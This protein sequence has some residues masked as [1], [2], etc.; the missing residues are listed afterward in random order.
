MSYVTRPLLT[1]RTEVGGLEILERISED[2]RGLCQEA[3]VSEPFYQPD[4]SE[5]YVRAFSP[6]G[7][8]ILFTVWNGEKLR[9]YLPL[10]LINSVVSGLPARKLVSCASQF[11]CRFDLIC[12]T[13]QEREE[14][15][16]AMWREINR[17]RKWDALELPYVQEGSGID[18]LLKLAKRDGYSVA[19]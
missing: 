8:L 2:A 6:Q 9:A 18:E 14:V 11:A 13:G 10:M 4:W 17:L 16:R 5:A 12:C 19:R 15:L 1:V 7:K 3:N